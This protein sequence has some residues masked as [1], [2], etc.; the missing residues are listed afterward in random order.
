LFKFLVAFLIYN[1]GIGVIITV[2]VIYGT[3]LGFGTIELTLAILLVQF[4]GIPYSLIFG[5]LPSKS[6]KRQ[7][8]FTAFVIFNIIMLPLVGIASSRF[9]PQGLTGTP[10]PDF[11]TTATAVGQ[12]TYTVNDDAI[13]LDGDWQVETVSAE[14]LGE[15]CA[16]YAFWCDAGE[17]SVD[18]AFSNDAQARFD[19]AFNGQ[20]VEIIYAT[21]PE[22]G[23]WAIEIDG[24]PLLDGEAPVTIDA[25]NA[26]ARYSVKSAFQAD[27]EGEHVL[28]VINTGEAN[29]DSN[30][31]AMA[32]SQIE[33]KPPLRASNLGAI[34]GIL[35]VTQIVGL[36]FAFLLG[37]L[38]FKGIAERMDTKRAIMLALSA[39]FIIAV[40]G[41]FLNSVVEFWFLA[42]MVAV[43]QGG[44]QA[45]SRSLYA[46]MSPTALSG[47]FF[48]FFSIMSK[49]ASF[50][51]PLVFVASVAIWN[52][53]RPGVLALVVFFGLGMYLL[54][55]V[56]VEEGRRIAREKDIELLG[57]STD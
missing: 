26:T 53:S 36:I 44:S 34:L 11:E 32:V 23:I 18:Y 27:S 50:L 57:S 55:R 41:F 17:R 8:M 12:G 19:V 3:E 48:G 30:G 52:S 51:S 29:P 21:G 10:S 40:W 39:Y 54:T 25:Y 22:S 20:P 56:N 47:E 28:S 24:Q 14:L 46:S 37:P 49:F 42:W 31:T 7:T 2:A 4:V 33:V 16:W 9:L 45:L 1:D 35:I 6:N 15:A 13:V 43:V 38:F 5:N